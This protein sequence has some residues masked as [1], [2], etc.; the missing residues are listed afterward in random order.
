MFEK[1][2]V[3]I[4]FSS[5]SSDV[6]ETAVFLAKANGRKLM[7]LHVLPIEDLMGKAVRKVYEKEWQRFLQ[8]RLEF[9]RSLVRE[10]TTVGVNAEFTIFWGIPGR[11]ICETAQISRPG[12]PQKIVNS[13]LT[14]TVVASRTKERKNSSLCCKNLCHSFS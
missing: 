2:L 10:A 8:Q 7:L 3:A 12:I 9:L 4:D 14:P 6:F 13:A 11:D 5:E 1:I